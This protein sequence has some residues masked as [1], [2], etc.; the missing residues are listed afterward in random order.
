ML[1]AALFFKVVTQLFGILHVKHAM[2]GCGFV[3]F[4]KLKNKRKR[5]LVLPMDSLA[6]VKMTRITSP[7]TFAHKKLVGNKFSCRL[8]NS[9]SPRKILVTSYNRPKGNM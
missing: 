9:T 4:L 1:C 6:L 2:L 7:C 8:F 3:A 5:K